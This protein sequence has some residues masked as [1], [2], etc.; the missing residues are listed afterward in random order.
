MPFDKDSLLSYLDNDGP[1]R[2]GFILQDGQIIEVANVCHDPVNGFEVSGEELIK[3]EDV[4]VASWH[5]H[6]NT[7]SNL[8]FGDYTSFLNYPKLAHYIVGTDGVAC[9]TVENGKVLNA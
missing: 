1:E 2:V 8:S 6:P 5:T 9:Y 4:A 7:D 3:Y